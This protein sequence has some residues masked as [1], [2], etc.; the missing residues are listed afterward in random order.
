MMKKVASNFEVSSSYA[1]LVSL[2]RSSNIGFYKSLASMTVT[3]RVQLG[4]FFKNAQLSILQ[5]D[6][7]NQLERLSGV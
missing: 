3:V 6:V 7:L 5:I 4:C 1:H 2:M